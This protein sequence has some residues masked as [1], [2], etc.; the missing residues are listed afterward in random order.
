MRVVLVPGALALLPKYAGLADPVADLRA[1]C[2]DAVAW[3]QW[4]ADLLA[5]G[6][7]RE[8]GQHLLDVTGPR[9]PDDSGRATSLL[10]VA[11]GSA[12]RTEKAPGHLDPRAAAF[13][14]ALGR[15]LRGPDVEALAAIDPAL[16]RELL[17]DTEALARL[18]TFLSPQAEVTVDYEDDPFGVQ[19]WV[20]RWEQPDAEAWVP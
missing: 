11:N 16:S 9:E 6:P 17:A 12:R 1:A 18:A 8:V 19:Y 7:G 2:V 15:A 13:D 4:P 3:L 10:V 5:S 20:I 14:D